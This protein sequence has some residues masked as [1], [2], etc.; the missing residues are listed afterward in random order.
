MEFLSQNNLGTM[1]QAIIEDKNTD[2]EKRKFSMELLQIFN[3]LVEDQ[4]N[5]IAS[6]KL[7]DPDD[8]EL[9]KLVM[10]KRDELYYKIAYQYYYILCSIDP[11]KQEEYKKEFEMT[12]KKYEMEYSANRIQTDFGIQ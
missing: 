10:K 8:P 9:T 3:D 4:K 5:M 6:F 11:T 2:P 7:V 12:V 1:L